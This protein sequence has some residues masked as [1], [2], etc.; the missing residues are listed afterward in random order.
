MNHT[1]SRCRFMSW[2]PLILGKCAGF[3]QQSDTKPVDGD[4]LQCMERTG[5]WWFNKSVWIT[6][7]FSSRSIFFTSQEHS[8]I[9]QKVHFFLLIKRL[10]CKGMYRGNKT[11]ICWCGSFEQDECAERTK[12]HRTYVFNHKAVDMFKRLDQV[13]LPAL[14]SVWQYWKNNL[15]PFRQQDMWLFCIYVM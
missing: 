7:T 13:V 5:F 11:S 4:S 14:A 10:E 6:W 8:V 3:K 15:D 9:P 1:T 2:T 12:P